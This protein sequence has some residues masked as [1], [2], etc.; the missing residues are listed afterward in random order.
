MTKKEML[1]FI[2][3]ADKAYYEKSD[4]IM[5][6][7]EYDVLRRQYI[8]TYG[9]ADLNYVPSDVSDAD[10]DFVHPYEVISL[11][12][13]KAGDDAAMKAWLGKK[14]SKETGSVP[15]LPVHLQKKEDGCT[16]VSYMIDGKLT[17]VSRGDG[18][19]GKVLANVPKKYSRPIDSE[20]PV[21]SEA[22]FTK[23]DYEAIQKERAEQGLELF[24]NIRNAVS[25]VLQSKDR[26]PYLDRVTFVAYDLMGCPMSADEKLAY[27]KEHTNYDVVES[28][29]CETI[30]EALEMIPRLFEQWNAEDHPIDGVV[31]KSNVRNGLELF[32]STGH[33][34]LH[35]FAYK[36]EQEGFATTL[37]SVDWQV[38]REKVT[39]VA[40]FDPVE[41][42]GTTV[43]KA[44]V[45]NM[46]VIREKGLSIGAKILVIKSNQIIPFV[47][48]VL[49]PGDTPIVP[50]TH[51]PV[52]GEPLFER[53]DVL[54]CMNDS[55]RGRLVQNVDHITSKKVLDIRG[56]SESTIEKLVES[57]KIRSVFDIFR[58]TKEDFLSL[59]GF[60]DKSAQNVV[61]A[62]QGGRENVD[63]A[64][65]IAA[66]CVPNIG[67]TA[68][69]L[70]AA[71]YE[72]YEALLVA[73]EDKT[74]NF[75]EISGIGDVMNGLLH[76]ESFVKEFKAL[77][78]HIDPISKSA[79]A[80]GGTSYTFVI[81]GKLSNPRSYYEELI[82]AAGSKVAGSV[83]KNT[84]YLLCED[85]DSQST[86]AKKARSLGVKVISE[87]ELDGILG[88][89]EKEAPSV[90]K[91]TVQE[92]EQLLLF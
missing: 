73:L 19:K 85:A 12:K 54:F 82:K 32:G 61:N 66:C 60:K 47:E 83:S 20:W 13:V 62:I 11:G 28:V 31:V 3:Q 35:S 45:A 81:T 46:G 22:I 75:T 49:E 4:P 37:R 7:A 30:P 71:R 51:C 43:E 9:A 72:S 57:G 89:A 69:E 91:G 44:S 10:A 25:G 41:I 17:V 78:E 50:P 80:G 67:L 59:E 55:C 53:N 18:T 77:R 16:V 68:G 36:A 76:S 1:E 8:D 33:H 29:L 74:V 34:P 52:C 84:D 15:F 70:L 79:P 6:D 40:N 63:L 64:H 90:D 26:S 2:Q 38:G 23:A 65:F 87:S 14:S 56:I 92:E 58:L 42:D 5:S 21:R 48:K 86:K 27:I 24:K 88:S 39:A